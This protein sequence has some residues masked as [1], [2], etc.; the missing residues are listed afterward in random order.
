M[1]CL[2]TLRSIFL[3]RVALLQLAIHSNVFLLDMT[4]LSQIIPEKNLKQFTHDLFSSQN[5]LKLGKRN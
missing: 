1:C 3:S 5:I 4:A 2:S